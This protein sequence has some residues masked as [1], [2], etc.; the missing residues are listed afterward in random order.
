M[1]IDQH[2]S[3][4]NTPSRPATTEPHTAI[5]GA[6]AARAFDEQAVKEAIRALHT[7]PNLLAIGDQDLDEVIRQDRLDYEEELRYEAALL[8]SLQERRTQQHLGTI[9]TIHHL[10]TQTVQEVLPSQ[11]NLAS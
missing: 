9:A 1:R 6:Y 4:G 11:E 10:P 5:V 3:P 7:P 2:F 8:E